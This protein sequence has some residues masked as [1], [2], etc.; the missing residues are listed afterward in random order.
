[1]ADIL[2]EILASVELS[3]LSDFQSDESLPAAPS[4]V[5]VEKVE[6]VRGLYPP[7]LLHLWDQVDSLSAP[8]FYATRNICNMSKCNVPILDASG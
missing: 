8:D 5:T 4:F 2:A 7:A 3:R 6:L 1:M